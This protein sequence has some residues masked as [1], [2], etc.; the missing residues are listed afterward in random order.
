MGPLAS[1][2]SRRS[3]RDHDGTLSFRASLKRTLHAAR[4]TRFTQDI[5]PAATKGSKH[6]VCM[7]LNPITAHPSDPKDVLETHEHGR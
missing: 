7:V 6:R 2:E 3:C 1:E 5:A 4:P